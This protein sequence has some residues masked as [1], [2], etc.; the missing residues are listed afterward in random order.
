MQLPIAIVIYLSR[1]MDLLFYL[2]FGYWALRLTKYYTSIFFGILLLPTCLFLAGSCTQDVVLISASLCFIAGCLNLILND[3][4]ETIKLSDIVPLLIT[5]PFIASIKYLIYVPIFLLILFIPGR[6]FG[7]YR[8]LLLG[9]V[10]AGISLL[11]LFY[12]IYLLKEIPFIE[13]RNGYVDVGKQIKFVLRI[14]ISRIEILEHI[15]L[16]ISLNI[17]KMPLLKN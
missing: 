2:C 7:R 12:Q 3:E 6:K 8:K 4:V 17:F 9:V 11:L 5:I 13:D 10:I 16:R 1:F 15:F 14:C